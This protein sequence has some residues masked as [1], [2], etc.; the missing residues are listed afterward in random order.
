MMCRPSATTC[1]SVSRSSSLAHMHDLVSPVFYQAHEVS[2]THTTSRP[3]LAALCLGQF[4]W[5]KQGN[6]AR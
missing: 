3:D 5:W 1:S 6:K 4:I 2:D